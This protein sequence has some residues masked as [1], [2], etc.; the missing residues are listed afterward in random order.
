MGKLFRESL[1]LFR[2]F[3]Y[4]FSNPNPKDNP[5]LS[6]I[7]WKTLAANNVGSLSNTEVALLNITGSYQTG[8]KFT[9]TEGFYPERLQFWESV[10]NT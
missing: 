8:S 7:D 10:L 5:V 6:N 3:Y 1:T 2:L 9:I 4:I